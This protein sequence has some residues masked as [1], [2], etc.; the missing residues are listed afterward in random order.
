MISYIRVESDSLNVQRK[1]LLNVKGPNYHCRVYTV[2]SSVW[3]SGH[4]AIVPTW[5]YQGPIALSGSSLGT[6]LHVLERSSRVALWH[7]HS[8]LAQSTG[9]VY[10]G[11]YSS[12]FELRLHCTTI[13]ANVLVA[14][15]VLPHSPTS[16]IQR[17]IMLIITRSALPTRSLLSIPTRLLLWIA[18]SRHSAST[19]SIPSRLFG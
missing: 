6:D 11:V 9:T 16:F 19:Q 3:R 8:L 14:F 13:S 12:K 2:E 7:W 10:C 15:W 18:L 1:S 5:Y 17:S 4:A